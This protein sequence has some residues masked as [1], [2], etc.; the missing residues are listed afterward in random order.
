MKL[1]RRSNIRVSFALATM[2][3]LHRYQ[4]HLGPCLSSSNTLPA[5]I[6]IDNKRRNALGIC[7]LAQP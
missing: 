1:F 7:D 2:Y 6:F 5:M 3:K 4:F